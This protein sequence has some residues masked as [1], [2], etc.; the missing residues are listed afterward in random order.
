MQLMTDRIQKTN[1]H[2]VEGYFFEGLRA[3]CHHGVERLKGAEHAGLIAFPK[4]QTTGFLQT[5]V[6]SLMPQDS[7]PDQLLRDLGWGDGL[8]NEFV[9]E[10]T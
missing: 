6:P 10:C 5:F 2:L 7:H 8:W 1:T 9:W 3:T 4:V